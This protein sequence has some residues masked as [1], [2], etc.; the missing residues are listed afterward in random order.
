METG[1]ATVQSNID[2]YPWY[3]FFRDCHFWGPVFF[4][5]FTSVVSLSQAL[6]LEAVYYV[7]VALMEVPSGYL[8]DR[9]GRRGTLFISSISLSIAYLL[10]F[11]GTTFFPFVVAQIFLAAGFASASGTDTAFHYESLKALHR[12]EEYAVR[13]GR[14]LRFVFIAGGVSAI[15][16][17]MMAT[18][19]LKWVYGASFLGAVLSGGMVWFMVEPE[20]GQ[21]V[22]VIPFH[23]QVKG[24]LGKAW[25]PRLRFFTFYSLGMTVLLHLPYE[26]YQ[27]YLSAV[28]HHLGREASLTPALAGM[29]LA[30]TFLVGAWLTRYAGHIHHR[31]VVRKTLL[32]CAL[33]QA[34]LVG[35]MALTL[36][37]VVALLLVG[38]TASRALLTPLVNAELSPLLHHHERS[39]YLSL[40]SLLGRLCYGGVL[41]VLPAGAALFQDPFHGTLICASLF[42]GVI[43]VIFFIIPFP[44]DASHVCCQNHR[45][46]M[47]GKG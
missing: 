3:L 15:L 1:L 7:G 10:F 9:F 6:Y 32:G 36:H 20:K 2:R 42:A 23:H 30:A 5:Y 39:T 11:L 34:M 13:E 18:G 47:T 8:S 41:L 12:E 37:P 22:S 19:H 46:F 17:G 45:P 4:L 28:A 33:L 25:G 27:P 16:G 40:Q 44:K 24:L 38:R 26:F 21:E 29:H 43:L 14:A 31:C 35:V